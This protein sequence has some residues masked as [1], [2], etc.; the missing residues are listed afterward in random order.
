MS[1]GDTQAYLMRRSWEESGQ[2]EAWR[3]EAV[4]DEGAAGRGVGSSE[5]CVQR[6]RLCPEGL[7]SHV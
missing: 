1:G 5:E 4:A 2:C 3:G 6:R 7:A